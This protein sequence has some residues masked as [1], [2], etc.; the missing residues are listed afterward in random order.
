[1]I[2]PAELRKTVKELFRV[3]LTE[4]L[5]WY[6]RLEVTCD[7][8]LPD[9]PCMVV[10]NHGFGGIV[11]LNVMA[12]AVA[13]RSIGNDRPLTFLV[14]QVAWTLGAGRLVE[15][16]GGRKA[17]RA[18]AEEAIANGHH[19]VVFPGGDIDAGK[20][21]RDR[22]TITFA[23]RS[24]FAR[25]ARDLGVPIVPVVTAGA[26][27]SLYVLSDGTKLAH[28]LG[29][30]KTLRVKALPV[31]LSIPWGISF[32]L[33]GLVPYV[34]LPTKLATAVLGAVHP[35]VED[36]PDMLARAILDQ[37]QTRMDEL[38]RARVPVVG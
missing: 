22:N 9:E 3:S 21:F 27:E 5:K 38:V 32:G 35:T 8:P 14:H 16:G 19:L 24:G 18:A 34:P 13:M 17:C 7:S 4:Y 6:H 15:L 36:D 37:M 30:S 11:D 23:G 29:I 1:M 28:R 25:L 33:T 31:S 12:V 20:A 26:G 2:T 10:C